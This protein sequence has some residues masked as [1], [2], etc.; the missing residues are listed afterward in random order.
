VVIDELGDQPWSTGLSLAEI[1]EPGHQRPREPE[2]DL[3]A[4]P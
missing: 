4:E 1:L 3:E 2:A